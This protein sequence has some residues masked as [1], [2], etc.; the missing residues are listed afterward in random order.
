MQSIHVRR[1]GPGGP[2]GFLGTVEP[3]DRSWIIYVDKQNQAS[4]WRRRETTDEE[5]RVEH[6]YYNAEG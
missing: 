6:S 2:A 1:Y 4:F 3:D 5:G